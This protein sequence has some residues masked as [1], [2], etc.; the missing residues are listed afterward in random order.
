MSSPSEFVVKVLVLGDAATGKTS[1]IKQYVYSSFSDQHVATATVD[2][3]LK[4]VQKNDNTYRVQLWDIAGQDHFQNISRVYYR[5]ALAC[6]IVCDNTRKETLDNV[7]KWKSQISEKTSLPNGKPLPV[8][9]LV[10]K[11]DIEQNPLPDEAIE[12]IC[13]ENNI[14]SW[15]KVSAKTG[16]NI[17]NAVEKL[18]DSVIA[19]D[20]IWETEPEDTVTATIKPEKKG[21]CK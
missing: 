18:L 12:G 10:N 11:C 16:M 4:L 2:F 1:I 8:I 13:K 3:T 6:F 21:C 9:L 5:N 19:Y 20:D 17:C 15:M 7:A 14:D